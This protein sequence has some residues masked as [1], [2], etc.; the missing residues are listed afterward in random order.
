MSRMKV[1]IALQTDGNADGNY[2]ELWRIIM[3]SS[4]RSML[5][6]DTQ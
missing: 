6:F 1:E 2:A 5:K 3:N 4:E